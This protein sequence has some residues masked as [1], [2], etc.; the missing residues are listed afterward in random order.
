MTTFVRSTLERAGKTALQL[1]LAAWTLSAG[2]LDTD[3]TQPQ[4]SAFDH[5]FDL[6]NLKA[7]AVGFVFSIGTSLLSR[8]IGPDDS[9]SLVVKEE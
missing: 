3:F 8:P 4:A 5:M 1:Y 7:A 2:L 6:D 9:A